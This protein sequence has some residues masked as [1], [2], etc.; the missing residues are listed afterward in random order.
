MKAGSPRSSTELT[1]TLKNR[2]RRAPGYTQV[3]SCIE[4]TDP[5]LS[6][7]GRYVLGI[8]SSRLL[9]S[10]SVS[11]PQEMLKA[12]AKL[13][14]YTRQRISNIDIFI[15]GIDTLTPFDC[16]EVKIMP[17]E[18]QFLSFRYSQGLVQVR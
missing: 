8:C 18:I 13:L 9:P 6:H 12:A 3:L 11:I 17:L 7:G 10:S 4:G 16:R 5:L 15:A 2:E 1:Q 14:L